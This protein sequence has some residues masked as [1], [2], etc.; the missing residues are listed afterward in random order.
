[1]RIAVINNY[2]SF[3]YNLVR[4][5]KEESKGEVEVFRNDE[6]SIESLENVDGI[7]LS[8]GPGLPKDAGKMPEIIAR[9]HT[10][11][12]MLG[13]CL[14]HQALAEFFGR[15]LVQ[16][17]SPLHGKSSTL[18]NHLNCAMLEGI[19]TEFEAGRYHSWNVENRENDALFTT[20]SSPD[21]QIMG[22]AHRSL[23]LFGFQFHPESILTP[24]GRQMIRNWVDSLKDTSST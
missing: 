11:T 12:P 13:I 10:R 24:H 8:P 15:S 21:G 17:E 7:L 14:G 1:M 23:P 2:D 18:T 20:C 9:Y 5:L 16:Q 6:V 4:Y 22:L 3:V 19:P